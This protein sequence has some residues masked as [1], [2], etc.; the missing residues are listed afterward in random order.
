M[1]GITLVAEGAEEVLSSEEVSCWG[2]L[3]RA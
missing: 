3:L 2:I 1:A